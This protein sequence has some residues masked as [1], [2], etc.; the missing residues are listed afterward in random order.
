MLLVKNPPANTGDLG[1]TS[2]SGRSPREG[3]GNFKYFCVGDPMD[4]RARHTT[5]LG[6]T[7]ELD[8]T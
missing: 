7:R 1:S 8:M 6:V 3:N 5:V 2:V 4:T